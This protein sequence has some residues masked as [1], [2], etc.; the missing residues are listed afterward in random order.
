MDGLSTAANIFGAIE[1]TGKIVK[2]CGRYI[3]DVKNARDDIITL[4][5]SAA[6]L[7]DILLNLKKLFRDHGSKLSVSSNLAENIND[8][9]SDLEALETKIN[10]GH[11]KGVMRKFGIRALKWPIQR[12]EVDRFVENLERYKSSF[13]LSMQVDQT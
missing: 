12:P 13:I 4:Q 5:R 2:I 3:T 9:I 1:L 7:E 11:K 8:C 10:P 6:G